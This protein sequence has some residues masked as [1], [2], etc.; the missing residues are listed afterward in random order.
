[1]KLGHAALVRSRTSL[2]Q[3]RALLRQLLAAGG[4]ALL[5]TYP[6][7]AA[8]ALRFE[9][10]PFSLG[11]ASGYPLPDDVVLWTR[12]A[13][14]PLAPGGGMPREVVPVDWEVAADA[15]FSRIVRSGVTYAEP[16]WA[17]SVHVEPGGLEPGRS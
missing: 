13:P 1:M 5:P 4:L 14:T 15:Q 6:R 17:H 10:D 3:R 7:R 11:V 16:D 8:G 2:Q 12:L 9:A